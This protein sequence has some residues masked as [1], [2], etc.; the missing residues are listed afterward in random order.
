M[1]T[2]PRGGWLV[3]GSA[4]GLFVALGPAKF[5]V[6]CKQDSLSGDIVCWHCVVPFHCSAAYMTL[7]CKQACM[8]PGCLQVKP[9]EVRPS[10]D[11]AVVSMEPARLSKCS[12]C[13]SCAYMYCTELS[14]GVPLPVP[15]QAGQPAEAPFAE[16]SALGGAPAPGPA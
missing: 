14:F 13:V 7:N 2:P 5:Q 8:V 1:C 6:D 9:P 12:I 4:A 11:F 15:L 3:V 10:D 16:P